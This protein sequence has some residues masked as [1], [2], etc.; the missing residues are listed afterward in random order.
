MQERW[1]PRDLITE[2]M[3]GGFLRPPLIE[4]SPAFQLSLAPLTWSSREAVDKWLVPPGSREMLE[5]RLSE[6]AVLAPVRKAGERVLRRSRAFAVFRD[7]LNAHVT[8][9]FVVGS[10]LFLL[11]SVF[12][13]AGRAEYDP[14]LPPRPGSNGRPL[15]PPLLV[16]PFRTTTNRRA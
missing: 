11:S 7:P 5:G 1:P 16:S 3:S 4:I 6:E 14:V 15:L 10:V 13:L 12:G 9:M 2:V 8:A